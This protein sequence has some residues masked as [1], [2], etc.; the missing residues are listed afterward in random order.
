MTKK[1][2]L[3]LLIP[4]ICLSQAIV[5]PHRP[6]ITMENAPG[7]A[8]TPATLILTTSFQANWRLMRGGSSYTL[9]VSTD[10][11]FGSFVGSYHNYSVSGTSQSVTGLSANTTYYYRVKVTKGT[12]FTSNTVRVST[13]SLEY[14]VLTNGDQIVS[15][16]GHT[17][18][19]R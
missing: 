16:S 5:P 7:F 11:L 1:L 3:L 14:L 2:F 8:A 9:D 15:P 6:G 13:K 17:L 18:I 12:S 19:V 10:P 4:A